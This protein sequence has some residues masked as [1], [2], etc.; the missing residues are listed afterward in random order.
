MTTKYP[1]LFN[2]TTYDLL[3]PLVSAQNVSAGSEGSVVLPHDRYGV[4]LEF[5]KYTR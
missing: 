3:T 4:S 1:L 2:V 5:P